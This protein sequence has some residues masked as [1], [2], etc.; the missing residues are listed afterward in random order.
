[1]RKMM[2]CSPF[3]YHSYAAPDKYSMLELVLDFAASLLY[4]YH[5]KK[6]SQGLAS[7]FTY[8]IYDIFTNLYKHKIWKH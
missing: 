3:Q 1:M 4:S 2:F 5:G 7:M 6:F 8:L